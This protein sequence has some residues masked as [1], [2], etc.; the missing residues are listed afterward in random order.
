MYLSSKLSRATNLLLAVL[1]DPESLTRKFIQW[2]SFHHTEVAEIH[3]DNNNHHHLRISWRHK[4]QT[5][6]QGR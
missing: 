4:S 2:F 3:N 5:K 6:L 1:K